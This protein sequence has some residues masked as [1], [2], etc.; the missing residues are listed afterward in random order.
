LNPPNEEEWL[1]YV[2]SGLRYHGF[3]L[4]A[5]ERLIFLATDG[6]GWKR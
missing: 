5:I 2:R 6:G 1:Q 3:S 4:V